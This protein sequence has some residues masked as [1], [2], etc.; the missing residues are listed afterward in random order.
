LVAE[1]RL[2]VVDRF[3]FGLAVRALR[4]RRGWRQC[5]LG[6]RVGLSPAT[7]SRIETGRI[8]RIAVDDLAAVTSE[9][10]GRFGLDV[11]WRG[12]AIDR[13]I[14]ERHATLVDATVRWLARAGWTAEVE[15]SFSI[16]GERGSIDVLGRK[17]P[18][19][20]LIVVE[21]KTSLANVNEPLLGLDR[22]ARLAPRIARERGWASTSVGRLL[23]VPDGTTSRTQVER[24]AS[25]L[26][27]ALPADRRTVLAWLAAPIGPAPR[28][29]VF[30]NVPGL[31]PVNA[32][33]RQT[34]RH[35]TFPQGADLDAPRAFTS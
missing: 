21:V 19:G 8:G 1:L 33:R 7:I 16:A 35:G 11:W 12:A 18:A 3:R 32:V 2:R 29:I 9:L 10:G 26:R 5:D 17:E 34:S 22:K 15:V 23:V 31:H 25:S 13:L 24:H 14:D 27:T 6:A 20:A 4:R 30:L 28:G